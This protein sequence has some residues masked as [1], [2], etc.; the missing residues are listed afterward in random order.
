MVEPLRIAG[1]MWSVDV[2]V[3]EIYN[4]R[5]RFLRFCA[6]DDA[7]LLRFLRPIVIL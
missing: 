1:P 5:V 3:L 4:E 6:Q 2:S 7:S